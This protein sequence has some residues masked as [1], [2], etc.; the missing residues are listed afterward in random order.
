MRAASKSGSPAPA[1]FYRLLLE[2]EVRRP[3]WEYESDEEFLR[4][5][6]SAVQ[7]HQEL[8][9]RDI[10]HEDI[11]PGNVHLCKKGADAGRVSTWGY[12]MNF[13]HASLPSKLA[14][15]LCVAA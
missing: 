11:S 14:R 7:V 4:C 12:L 10:P 5:L 1:I 6:M 3:L 2:N 15:S 13:D 9:E 8:C